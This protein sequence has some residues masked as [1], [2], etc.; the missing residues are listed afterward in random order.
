MPQ[1]VVT[2]ISLGG[3]QV[4]RVVTHPDG[5]YTVDAPGAGNYVRQD[6]GYAFTDLD[7]GEYTAMAAGHPPKVTNRG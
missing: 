7:G 5:S 1:A 6:G 2:L 3:R 4:G